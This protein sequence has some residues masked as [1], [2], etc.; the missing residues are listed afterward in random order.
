LIERTLETYA[1][2]VTGWLPMG[3]L[4][5]DPYEVMELKSQLR[6]AYA[7]LQNQRDLLTFSKSEVESLR[8]E[9]TDA[10]ASLAKA[11]QRSAEESTRFFSLLEGLVAYNAD[12]SSTLRS[13]SVISLP[14]LSVWY[15]G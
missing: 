7:Q 1:L 14:I 5:V 9:F 4:T 15:L 10:K 8:A 2:V 12:L 3:D 6:V 13:M 11:E